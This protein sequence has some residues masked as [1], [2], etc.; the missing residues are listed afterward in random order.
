MG[1]EGELQS[2]DLKRA[3]NESAQENHPEHFFSNKNE[4]VSKYLL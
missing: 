2:A 4:R 3:K 1:K